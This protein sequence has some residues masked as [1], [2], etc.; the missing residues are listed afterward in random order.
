MQFTVYDDHLEVATETN[1]KN[2][3]AMRISFS[4]IENGWRV[5]RSVS[6]SG[7]WRM[8]ER[9]YV[10]SNYD[11][12]YILNTS[13]FPIVKENESLSSYQ[14]ISTGNSGGY[15][16]SGSYGS[17]T[18]S[19]T[20]SSSSNVSRT[21]CPNCVND[22]RVYES[23]VPYSGTQTRYSTCSECGLRYMSSHRTHRHDRCDTCHGS[24]YLD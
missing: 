6:G 20:T 12:K 7:Q 19:R 14:R 8:D 22:R 21:D 16:S 10:S 18:S 5:Y 1:V 15:S 3:N 9:Y 2:G 11:I 4:G 17:G 23:T 24:G 13:E